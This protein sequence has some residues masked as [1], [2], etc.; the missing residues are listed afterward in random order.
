MRLHNVLK[1]KDYLLGYLLDKA[2][3]LAS[4][5]AVK[6]VER[7]VEVGLKKERDQGEIAVLSYS[8]GYCGWHISGQKKLFW[9]LRPQEIG[10]TLNE[11][12]L[13][14]PLKSVTGVLVAARPALHRFKAN[15]PFCISCR[16]HTCQERMKRLIH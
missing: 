11:Y 13:M 16:D 15:Y 1:E 9:R 8:P 2:A 14:A 3:S 4:D 12:I 5:R 10:I 7:D 6:V